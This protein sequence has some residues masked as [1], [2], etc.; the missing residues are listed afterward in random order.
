ML[1]AKTNLLIGQIICIPQC[2]PFSL[3]LLLF[4][5]IERGENKNNERGIAIG[6]KQNRDTQCKILMIIHYTGGLEYWVKLWN[7]YYSIVFDQP[8]AHPVSYG[9]IQYYEWTLKIIPEHHFMFRGSQNFNGP[10]NSSHLDTCS[11]ILLSGL[12]THWGGDYWRSRWT[13]GMSRK[14]T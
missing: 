10:M 11:L 2:S 12:V 13:Q 8:P 14:E 9:P 7:V 3:S 5:D 6:E 4:L 1:T